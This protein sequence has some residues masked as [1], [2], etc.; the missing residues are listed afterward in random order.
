MTDIMASIGLVEL[1]RYD[2]ET[3]PKRK[4]IF[5]AYTGAFANL[6]YCTTP[7]YKNPDKET[8]YHLYPLR[9]IGISE[10]QRDAIIA[11]IFDKKVSV[12]VHFI[13]VPM[14][15]Y[16]KGKGYDINNYPTAKHLYETE[17]SLPVW[18]GMTPEQIQTVIQAV[19]D[20]IHE[21]LS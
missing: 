21:I 14:M 9:I 12:N 16:Y 18:V 20:A 10:Q 17:I 1:S 2:E 8:S 6:K 11:S 4:A 13:P 19:S 15:S 3:L 7:E 5:D